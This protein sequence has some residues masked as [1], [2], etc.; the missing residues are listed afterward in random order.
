MRKLFEEMQ[1]LNEVNKNDIEDVQDDL[2][3]IIDKL[4]RGGVA[5]PGGGDVSQA[6]TKLRDAWRDLGNAV[7][8]ILGNL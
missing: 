6:M 3:R 8:V 2:T 4:Q 7:E 1:H 5:G